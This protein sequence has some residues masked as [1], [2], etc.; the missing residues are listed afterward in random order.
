[1]PRFL[2]RTL[3]G[4]V[5]SL[6]LTA[7]GLLAATSG[8]GSTVFHRPAVPGSSFGLLRSETKTEAFRKAV[9]KDDFPSAGEAGLPACD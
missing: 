9:R 3:S 4:P 2:L 6:L 5:P 7:A 1:M 8:C